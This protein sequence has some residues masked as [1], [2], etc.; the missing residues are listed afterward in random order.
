MGSNS[1]YKRNIFS[2]CNQSETS[3][4]R[5]DKIFANDLNLTAVEVRKFPDV[6]LID[7]RNKSSC[8]KSTNY[9][10]RWDVRVNFQTD[11]DKLNL[12]INRNRD[13]LYLKSDETNVE[14]LLQ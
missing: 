11:T 5:T 6:E 2:S 3:S 13:K 1:W 4:S 8:L 14:F 9:I 10:S 7:P 12:V